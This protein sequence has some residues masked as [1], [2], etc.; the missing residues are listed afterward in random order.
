MSA[1]PVVA[2]LMAASPADYVCVDLQ[3]G[4]ATFAELPSIV[5]AMRASGRVPLVRV[6]GVDQAQAMRALDLGAG[7]VIVPMVN[8]AADACLVASAC[9]YPNRGVRSWGLP[10][11]GIALEP[12]PIPA[13]LDGQV[14]CIAQ[15][16]T[17]EA[18]ANAEAIT[19]TDGIDAIYIGPNDLA[20]QCG[21]GRATY[22]DSDRVHELLDE[23]IAAARTVGKPV[24][25]HC[26]DPAMAEYW[27]ARGVQMAT[28]GHDLSVLA[29]AVRALFE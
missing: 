27:I 15:I 26:E 17:P 2:E 18:L 28:I 7:G 13:A 29:N 14:L 25:L 5:Q 20:L 10:W 6:G 3:H 12:N 9:R 4:M 16:E 8:T 23:I 24:G 11:S 22:R 21:L 19:A 1:D